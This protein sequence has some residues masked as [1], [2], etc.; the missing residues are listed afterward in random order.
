VARGTTT[1]PV[2]LRFA[3]GGSSPFRGTARLHVLAPVSADSAPVPIRYD[4][5]SR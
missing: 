2:R 3:V 1:V 4:C 5:P